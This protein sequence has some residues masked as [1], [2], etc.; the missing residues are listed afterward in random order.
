MMG[1]KLTKGAVFHILYSS[2]NK[3]SRPVH[4][5]AAAETIAVGYSVEEGKMLVE[6]LQHFFGLQVELMIA[7]DSKDLY[8]SLSTCRTPAD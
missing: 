8:D 4:S 1:R 6:A 2:S 3:S 7:V 5:T